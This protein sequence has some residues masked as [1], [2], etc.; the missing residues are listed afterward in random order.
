MSSSKEF[1]I[2]IVG[3]NWYMNCQELF[4][5]SYMFKLLNFIKQENK[6]GI[7]YP[8]EK[9]IFKALRLTDFKN[10][11]VIIVGQDPYFTE[12]NGVPDAT[13]L[14]FANPEEKLQPNPSLEVIRNTIERDCYAGIKL[15]FDYSL[16]SWAKQG[17]LLL[18]T[19]LTVKKY[20]PTSH[21]KVWSKFTELL[22]KSLN[23]KKTGLHFV[24]WG[25]HAKSYSHLIDS[26]KH[27]KYK[28]VHPAYAA[29]KN[30]DWQCT[31]FRDINL[32]IAKQNGEDFIITW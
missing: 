30:I 12:T 20:S 32:N 21:T 15:H 17:V 29:K 27:F 18:N 28:S 9:N 2:N 6:S 24:M 26:N 3:K 7:I 1:W 25:T 13:G 31:H 14:A 8:K 4:D 16:E 10:V 5:S 11:R 19:A 23:D 22:L